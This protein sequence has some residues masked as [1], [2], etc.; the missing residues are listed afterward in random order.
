MPTTIADFAKPVT[1]KNASASG[2]TG[3]LRYWPKQ[4]GST[5][6]VGISAAEIID[7]ENGQIDLATIYEAPSA[8]WMNGGAA[9]GASAG[10][11]LLQCF[12]AASYT[13]PVVYL[14]ADSEGM[15]TTA[16][17]ACLDAAASVISKSTVGLYGYLDELIA[18]HSGNHA[19]HYWLAGHFPATSIAAMQAAY[20]WINLYQCQGSQPSGYATTVNA[21]GQTGDGDIALQSDWGQGMSVSAADVTNIANATAQAVLNTLIAFRPVDSD[22]HARNLWDAEYQELADILGVTASEA[23]T[24]S[25][26]QNADADV[27]SGISQLVTAVTSQPSATTLDVNSIVAGVVADLPSQVTPAEFMAALATQLT[28]VK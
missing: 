2:L 25:A 16:I 11:W 22:G 10:K 5:V 28:V 26:V 19:S 21:G 14:A 20:P 27:K 12:A 4:G 9:A 3:L 6:V 8:T 23:A 7:L 15:S 13:P 17:N 18:A 1:A 24:L